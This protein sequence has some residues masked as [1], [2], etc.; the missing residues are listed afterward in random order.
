MVRNAA[1]SAPASS[2]LVSIRRNRITRS[3][4]FECALRHRRGRPVQHAAVGRLQRAGTR[5]AGD[6]RPRAAGPVRDGQ[7]FA[8]HRSAAQAPVLDL[9]DPARRRAVTPGHL[10]TQQAHRRRHAAAL[11][12]RARRPASRAS[13]RSAGRSNRSNRR[14]RPG[15]SRAVSGLAPFLTLAEAL[16]SRGTATTLFY[17]ARTGAR[18][19]LR[20]CLR[21]PRRPDRRRDRRWQ[22]RR[23]RAS[24]PIPSTMRSRRSGPAKR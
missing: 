11:R 24:S 23:A 3:V 19:L 18:P 1:P 10:D 14:C 6:R 7:A 17:G 2:E 4:Y 20:G 9:R 12:R 8:Q 21:S 15:W 16:V 5:R 22:P 13:D